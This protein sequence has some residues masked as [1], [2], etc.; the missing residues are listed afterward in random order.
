MD[1][2]SS[3]ILKVSLVAPRGSGRDKHVT[4]GDGILRIHLLFSSKSW[5]KVEQSV[6]YLKSGIDAAAVRGVTDH[7]FCVGRVT[8]IPTS[9][10]FVK[11][12]SVIILHLKKKK[13][14]DWTFSFYGRPQKISGYSPDYENRES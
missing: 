6:D 13:K 1:S 14:D 10:T 7:H 8:N 3:P 9:P 4:I 12:H 2:R 11:C 5:N